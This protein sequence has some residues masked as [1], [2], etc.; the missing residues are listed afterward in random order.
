M[1]LYVDDEVLVI[2]ILIGEIHKTVVVA[3]R[4]VG[5]KGDIVVGLLYKWKSGSL[6]GCN[7]LLLGQQVWDDMLCYVAQVRNCSSPCGSIL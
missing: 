7:I 6:D 1:E 2:D 4:F 5:G 3:C